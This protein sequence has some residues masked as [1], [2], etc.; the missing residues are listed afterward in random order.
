MLFVFGSPSSLFFFPP[1]RTIWSRLCAGVAA[2]A[3]TPPA[4]GEFVADD[5]P[6]FSTR[7]E[8][9]FIP[10]VSIAASSAALYVLGPSFVLRFEDG[11]TR[12]AAEKL[13]DNLRFPSTLC[14]MI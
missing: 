5:L 12:H 3:K 11:H 4:T 10:D 2:Q 6:F 13:G 14:R 7:K 8:N 9:F 1:P